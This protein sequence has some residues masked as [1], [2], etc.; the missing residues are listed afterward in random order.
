MTMA[1]IS[2][3]H[4]LAWS[5]PVPPLE[6]QIAITAYLDEVVSRINTLEAEAE[7]AIALFKER[8]SAL[9]TAAVTGQI[10]VRG[11]VKEEAA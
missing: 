5:V 3:G 1:K 10:D 4:I 6:E 11:L 2:Q 9:I 7:R 8:R